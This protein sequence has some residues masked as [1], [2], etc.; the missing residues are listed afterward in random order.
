MIKNDK[1]VIALFISFTIFFNQ[2]GLSTP[3]PSYR[4]WKGAFLSENCISE[5]IPLLTQFCKY[6]LRGTFSATKI[7]LKFKLS[8]KFWNEIRF[9]G[10]YL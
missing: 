5:K 4:V 7:L 2:K 10:F 1:Q 8:K 9:E 3:L 6:L